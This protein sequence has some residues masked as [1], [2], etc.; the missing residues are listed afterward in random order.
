VGYNTQLINT[1]SKWLGWLYLCGGLLPFGLGSVPKLF[2][3]AV[4]LLQWGMQQ[5]GA[6]NIMHYLANF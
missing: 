2:K 6:C 3:V 5:Q 4:D 1:Y